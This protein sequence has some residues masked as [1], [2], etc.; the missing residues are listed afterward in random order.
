MTTRKKVALLAGVSEATVSRVLNAVGPIKEETKQRVLNAAEELNY[1]PNAIAQNFAR[2]RSGNLGVVLPFVPK[3]H[4]FST[5]YFSEILSGI[6]ME[7]KSRGYDLLLMFREP[8]E[9]TDY[10]LLFKRQKI[11]ACIILGAKDVAV[12]RAALNELSR[13]HLPFCLVNQHFADEEFNEVDADHVDGSYRA[14]KHLIEQGYRNIAF[15]N[16]PLDYSNSRDRLE[17]YTRALQEANLPLND[18]HMFEGN[19]SRTSGYNAVKDIL[20][21]IDQIDA[22]FAANDRMAVGLIQGLREHHVEAGKDIAVV[23]YDNSDAATLSVPELTSVHVPFYEMG[24]M[25]AAKVL[26]QVQSEEQSPVFQEKLPTKMMI[27]RSSKTDIK[28]KEV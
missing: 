13:L 7:V 17:G 4:I 12:E 14:V 21:H 16:G 10:S 23:G 24:M 19:Y 22:V 20:I 8:D 11:D 18:S 15:L 2:R 28:P 3:I 25:A 5:Y 6:G 9:A 1:H 27:R 26:D